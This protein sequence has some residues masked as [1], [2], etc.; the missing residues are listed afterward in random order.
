MA[1]HACQDIVLECLNVGRLSAGDEFGVEVEIAE[2][3]ELIEV[4]FDLESNEF[5][6][7][8]KRDSRRSLAHLEIQQKRSS[9]N[10]FLLQVL[11]EFSAKFALRRL[12]LAFE[13]AITVIRLE[14]VIEHHI[15]Y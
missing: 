12:D 14:E 8:T 4:V 5:H 10:R 11:H 2:E 13:Q 6:G 7:L 15:Q 3:F 1:H 9:R